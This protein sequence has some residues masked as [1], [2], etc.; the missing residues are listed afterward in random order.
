M[1]ER[2]YV[3]ECPYSKAAS[4]ENRKGSMVIQ[5]SSS[6]FGDS[7]I[8]SANSPRSQVAVGNSEA[9]KT[10][11]CNDDVRVSVPIKDKLFESSENQDNFEL[12]PR[13]DADHTEAS[14]SEGMPLLLV[15]DQ[16]MTGET[17]TETATEIMSLIMLL[18]LFWWREPM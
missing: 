2:V 9:S 18:T 6:S 17:E 5:S 13:I 3:R 7:D 11:P 15:A 4:P 10:T 14:I 16:P 1:D 8:T 12:R